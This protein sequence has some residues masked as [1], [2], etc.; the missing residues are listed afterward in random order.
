MN[1]VGLMHE[2]THDMRHASGF[3]CH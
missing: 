3:P 1:G 2:Y